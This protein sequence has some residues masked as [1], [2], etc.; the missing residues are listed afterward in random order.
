MNLMLAGIAV[1]GLLSVCEAADQTPPPTPVLVELFTSEG[2]SS[3]PPADELLAEFAKTQ[4]VASALIVPISLHVN[5]WNYSGWQDRFSSALF[6]QRQTDYTAALSAQTYTPQMI[7]DGRTEFVGSDR[8]AAMEAISSAARE[9]H[10]VIAMRSAMDD[11]GRVAI[12]LKVSNLPPLAKNASAEV[13]LAV[14]EDDLQ[15]AVH[16]GENSGHLLH[17]WAVARSLQRIGQIKSPADAN[18]FTASVQLDPSWNQSNLHL[19]TFVQEQPT[20]RVLASGSQR[21]K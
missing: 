4:P 13:M 11:K 5:Y 14:T 8:A 6:T 21:V 7:V 19:I 17:H 18:E 10:G 1:L 2:C 15:T 20:F 16:G 12:T 9:P 3:C